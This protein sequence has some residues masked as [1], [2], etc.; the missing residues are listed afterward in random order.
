M[1]MKKKTWVLGAILLGATVAYASTL[2]ME[3]NTNRNGGD[4]AGFVLTAPDPEVCRSACANDP[5]CQSYTYVK[6]GIQGVNARC[7]LKN[8][9]AKASANSCC[10]SGAR[11]PDP[12]PPGTITMEP[13]MN[14]YGS[15]YDGFDLSAPDPELCR[16]ACA[17]DANCR[18]YVYVKPGV[19]GLNAKCWLKNPAPPTTP[20]SNTTSGIKY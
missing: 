12:P 14:R 18:A 1:N 5:V 15:D 4:Y 9:V 7:W 10:I 11:L 19:Q 3:N 2:S 8:V 17:N 6:P 13:G 20:D 16:T